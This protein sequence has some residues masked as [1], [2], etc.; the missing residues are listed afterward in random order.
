MKATK[1][2]LVYLNT[3][4]GGLRLSSHPVWDVLL[5]HHFFPFVGL[6]TRI[7]FVSTQEKG[8]KEQ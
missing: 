2:E 1:T 5:V 6:F 3:T 7:E 4:P 8:A